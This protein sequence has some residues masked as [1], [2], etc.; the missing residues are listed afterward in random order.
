M[1]TFA[2]RKTATIRT[3]EGRTAWRRVRLLGCDIDPLTFRETVNEVDRLIQVGEPVQHCV[4]NAAKVVMLH[5]DSRLRE[6][7][8]GCQLVNVDGQSVVWASKLLG[9]PLPERVAGIDLFLALMGLAAR[10]GYSTYFLGARPEVVK[11]VGAR[12]R[13]EHPQL[14]IA[15]MHDG[16]FSADETGAVVEAIRKVAPDMLF[17]GMPSPKKEYWLAENLERLGV[18][19]T[20]GVGGSFDVYAGITK[21]APLWVQRCGLEWA[22]R[23]LQEPRRMWK[24]YLISNTRFSWLVLKEFLNSRCPGGWPAG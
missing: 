17:V 18:P 20:M 16:Y 8:A 9:H 7:A 6:I 24:R 21:R 10:R 5:A 22:V 3:D 14:H 13:M 23:L 4:I 11:K 12:A 2:R 1:W 15:G 19:F